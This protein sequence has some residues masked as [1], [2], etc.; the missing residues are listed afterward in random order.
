[1]LIFWQHVF[2]L[3]WS[4]RGLSGTG[5]GAWHHLEGSA[6]WSMARCLTPPQILWHKWCWGNLVTIPWVR[7]ERTYCGLNSP[8]LYCQVW[9]DSVVDQR[10]FH[11]LI[12]LRFGLKSP[13][14]YVRVQSFSYLHWGGC[15]SVSSAHILG[16]PCE[17]SSFWH[18]KSYTELHAA[19]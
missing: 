14:V 10:V 1:M 5:L 9:V 18:W 3:G 17:I 13:W 6:R 8:V 2:L 4:A 16:S 11:T 12:F 15:F 19:S 7:D